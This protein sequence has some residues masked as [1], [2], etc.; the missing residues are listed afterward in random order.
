MNTTAFQAALPDAPGVVTKT[1][2]GQPAAFIDRQMFFGTFGD[3][4]VAR[5]GPS[6]VAE[7]VGAGHATPFV[8][9]EGRPWE[10]YAQVDAAGDPATHR[11]LALEALRW[12][13]RL[14]PRAKP[15]K[16]PRR[17]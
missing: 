6:R 3:T 1:M 9:T 14:P 10:D 16:R 4:L 2:F 7:L 15:P 5:I 13:S 8:P 11:A 12:T 17:G